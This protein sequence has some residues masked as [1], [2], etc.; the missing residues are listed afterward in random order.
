MGLF[1]RLIFDMVYDWFHGRLF[2]SAAEQTMQIAERGHGRPQ[3]GLLKTGYTWLVWLCLK[4]IWGMVGLGMLRLWGLYDRARELADTNIADALKGVNN[5]RCVGEVAKDQRKLCDAYDSTLSRWYVTNVARSM[6]AIIPSCLVME[7]SDMW[8]E[9]SNSYA[10]W[11]IW[12]ISM[13]VVAVWIIQ[14]GAWVARL[15]GNLTTKARVRAVYQDQLYYHQHLPPMVREV[16]DEPRRIN[17][18]ALA[19]SAEGDTR[20]RQRRLST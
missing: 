4:M 14:L 16:L 8:S 1:G 9:I 5:N 20:T 13:V 12:I 7:C 6:H 18:S 19:V 3:K 2:E 10:A 11:S 15:C 17:M